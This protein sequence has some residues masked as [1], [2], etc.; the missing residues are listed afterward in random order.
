M[1]ICGERIKALRESMNYSQMKV[2]EIFGVGQSSI[3]RYE[4]G[5][6]S[7]PLELLVKIADYYDVSLDYLLGRTDNPQGK[8][9]DSNPKNGY[10]PDMASFVEMCFDPKS[11][12]N[13]RLKQTLLQMLGEEVGK[14]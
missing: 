4:K 7:P 10:G 8:L 3:V 6:A 1:K 9:Y 2:A 13:A 14:E 5:E 12:M 11:P